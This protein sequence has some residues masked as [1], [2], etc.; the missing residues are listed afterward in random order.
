M[1]SRESANT[2]FRGCLTKTATAE[3][4]ACLAHSHET[5][6]SQ[7]GSAL[8]GVEL[9]ISLYELD[10]LTAS[11]ERKGIYPSSGATPSGKPTR[12]AATR[13]QNEVLSLRDGNN[14]VV[15]S[16]VYFEDS[17][18]WRAGDRH[19]YESTIY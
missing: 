3:I 8:P 12:Y 13:V 10:P 11:I 5:I 1:I 15:I 9:M 17:P 18:F 14:R 19:Y 4:E 6:T 7:L 16:E 2:A